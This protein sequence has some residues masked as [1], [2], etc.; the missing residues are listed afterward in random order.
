MK[1]FDKVLRV[2]KESLIARV[3]AGISGRD[4]VE[5]LKYTS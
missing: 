4:L 3:E 1:H 2:D 5:K